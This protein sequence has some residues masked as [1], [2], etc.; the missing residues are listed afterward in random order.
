MTARTRVGAEGGCVPRLWTR[1]VV[2]LSTGVLP[3]GEVRHRYRQE[4]LAEMYSMSRAEQTAHTLSVMTHALSL[5][6][7]V[8]SDERPA[9]ETE[10]NRH[11]IT[12]RMNLHHVWHTESTEDGVRY[13]RCVRCGKDDDSGPPNPNGMIVTPG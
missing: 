12:C 7:A 4:L 13:R 5:R 6:A 1:Q 11:P 10:M 9:E 2:R 3:A 8:T